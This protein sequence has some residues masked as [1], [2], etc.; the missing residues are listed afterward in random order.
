MTDL[1]RIYRIGRRVSCGWLV[2]VV[3]F[4]VF[5]CVVDHRAWIFALTFG[6]TLP[7]SVGLVVFYWRRARR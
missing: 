3:A 5:I 4:A 6:F 2:L 7:V 1:A